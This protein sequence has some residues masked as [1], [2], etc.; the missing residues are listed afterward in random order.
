MAG[1]YC[2]PAQVAAQFIYASSFT[3]TGEPPLALV[4]TFIA[5]A[6]LDL[7]RAIA[8]AGTYKTN[9][10]GGIDAADTEAYAWMRD[11]S[12]QGTLY[13]L[14]QYLWSYGPLRKSQESMVPYQEEWPKLL[15]MLRA[16]EVNLESKGDT[17]AIHTT[18]ISPIA[19][20]GVR[21]AW[22]WST[23]TTPAESEFPDAAKSAS[24]HVEV[25]PLPT[26]ET[27]AYALLWIADSLGDPTGLTIPMSLSTL[28]IFEAPT[29]FEL[30]GVAGEVRVSGFRQGDS[31]VG[32]D[33]TVEF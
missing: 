1:T 23:D 19:P 4:N 17:A 29:A 27:S 26:G 20:T 13:R 3:A 10:A 8:Y 33:V 32:K 12:I 6:G 18:P 16:G 15:A 9:A 7:E 25:P 5:E 31:D 22:G 21:V 24:H 14:G 28:A 11:A 2:T 30:D